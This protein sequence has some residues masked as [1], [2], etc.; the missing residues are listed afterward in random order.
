MAGPPKAPFPGHPRTVMV[1]LLLLAFGGAALVVG[2]TLLQRSESGSAWNQ[3][4]LTRALPEANAPAQGG[5]WSDRVGAL[6]AEA[7]QLGPPPS[8]PS[9]LRPWLAAQCS[10]NRKLQALQQEFA[11]PVETAAEMGRPPACE[12]LAALQGP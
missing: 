9:R 6:L 4:A 11:R 8:D 10:L 12:Q 3:A 5:L 7:D 1:A 2:L